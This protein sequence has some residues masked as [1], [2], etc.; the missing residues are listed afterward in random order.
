MLR[1]GSLCFQTLIDLTHDCSEVTMLELPF[2]SSEYLRRNPTRFTELQQFLSR[3]RFPGED[4][5]EFFR[6]TPDCD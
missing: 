4:G 5:A 2:I 3:S 1:L 6:A